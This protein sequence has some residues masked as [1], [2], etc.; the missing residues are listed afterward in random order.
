MLN[1]ESKMRSDRII[2][3]RMLCRKTYGLRLSGSKMPTFSGRI[4]Y[5]LLISIGTM[6][7]IRKIVGPTVSA[8]SNQLN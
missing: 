2:N 8:L 7:A 1:I 5:R 6:A 3:M 4:R